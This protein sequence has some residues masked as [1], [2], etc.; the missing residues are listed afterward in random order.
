[1]F[2]ELIKVDGV[3]GRQAMIAAAGTEL[4]HVGIFEGESLDRKWSETQVL[5]TPQAGRDYIGKVRE[6]VEGLLR[7]MLRGEDAVVLSVVSGFVVGD[8]REK[9]RQ[10]NTNGI[11]PWDRPQFKKLVSFWTSNPPRLSIWRLL[12]T[13]AGFNLGM[14]EATDV[15]EHWR[16]HFVR[17][18]TAAFD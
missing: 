9:L 16:K 11:A 8:C 10:L 7:L 3:A 4:G 5:K 13:P 15:E 6:Y 12:I 1:M 14:A 2:L 18:S 17:P